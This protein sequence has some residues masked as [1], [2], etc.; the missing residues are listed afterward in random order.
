[1]S[2][3]EIRWQFSAAIKSRDY[4]AM[5][6]LLTEH[7]DYILGEYGGEYMH[8]A[9]SCN[10]PDAMQILLDYGVSISSLN[11]S[12]HPP[13]SSAIG[14]NALDAAKWLIAHGS[15]INKKYGERDIDICA[16]LFTASHHGTLEMAR[17]LVEA[18][19]NVNAYNRAGLTPLDF[20][21]MYGK[22]DI[23]AYLRSKGGFSGKE[24]PGAIPPPERGPIVEYIREHLGEPEPLAIG[25]LLPANPDVSIRRLYAGE[26]LLLFTNGMSKRAMSTPPGMEEF[27]YAELVM[28]LYDGW[29]A[30]END[31]RLSPEQLWPFE[32]LLRLAT[33]PF[34]ENTW[35]GHPVGII[36]NGEP[37][38][39]LAPDT[40]M[41][42]WLLVADARDLKPLELP[43]RRVYF[44]HAMPIHTAERD[45]E[46]REGWEAI[47]RLFEQKGVS[48]MI[49]PERESVV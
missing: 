1:V 14:N 6:N 9:A 16:A 29:S 12:D 34:E 8:H 30:T 38:E 17:L 22:K 25:S 43:D 7:R 18:G 37:P 15:L 32:W 24:I 19:A 28:H 13:L 10:N 31:L 5:R 23:A 46:R 40:A 27:R 35:L 36:A 2:K 21:E 48:F 4:N 39:P 41:T 42:C 47:L 3:P 11:L 44:Y 20:A 33:I 49:D 45:F 26:K